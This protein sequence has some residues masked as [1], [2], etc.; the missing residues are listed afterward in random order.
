ME[1]NTDTPYKREEAALKSSFFYV[2]EMSKT[3]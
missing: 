1:E 2:E 3:F